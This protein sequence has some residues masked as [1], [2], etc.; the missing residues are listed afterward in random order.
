MS[1]ATNLKKMKLSVL[2]SVVASVAALQIPIQP[3]NN[4]NLWSMLQNSAQFSDL[5]AVLEKEPLQEIKK[6]LQ[7]GN[8]DAKK[9][10]LFA[11]NNDAVKKMLQH[12]AP[13]ED[14]DWVDILKYH[15]VDGKNVKVIV[16][17]CI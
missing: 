2:F 17:V 4:E 9:K 11:P 16:D 6:I 7:D 5:V 8:S 3:E 1:E 12:H 15:F 13:K 10:T 14:K